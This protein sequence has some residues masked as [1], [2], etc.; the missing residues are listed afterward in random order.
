[1]FSLDAFFRKTLFS[2]KYLKKK[3]WTSQP[4]HRPKDFKFSQFGYQSGK[5]KNGIISSRL[6]RD[7]ADEKL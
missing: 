6:S 4:A 1:L 3:V 2:V 5:T 7:N